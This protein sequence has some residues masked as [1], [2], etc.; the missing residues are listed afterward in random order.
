MPDLW[1]QVLAEM[2]SKTHEVPVVIGDEEFFTGDVVRQPIVS[3]CVLHLVL[4]DVIV[5]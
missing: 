2:Q 5:L 3:V 1:L 4:N